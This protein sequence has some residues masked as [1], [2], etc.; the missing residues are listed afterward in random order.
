VKAAHAAVGWIRV[1]EIRVFASGNVGRIRCFSNAFTPCATMLDQT[2]ALE[3][4]R[5]PFSA[6]VPWGD[7]ISCYAAPDRAACADFIEEI[8]M[9]CAN[10]K[11]I[12]TGNPGNMGHP[13]RKHGLVVVREF[14]RSRGFKAQIVC[15]LLRHG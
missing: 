15:G 13:S 1:Q 7:R 10:A 5:P 9:K 8:R 11:N 6:H 3:G 14:F 4:L 12:E 2:K